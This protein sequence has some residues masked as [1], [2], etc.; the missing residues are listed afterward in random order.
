PRS[1]SPRS[2]DERRRSHLRVLSRARRA[3][4]AAAAAVHAGALRRAVVHR[5]PPGERA[6]VQGHPARPGGPRR[7]PPAVRRG[8][9]AVARPAR[10][11]AHAHR[12]GAALVARVAAAAALRAVPRL[13]WQLERRAERAVP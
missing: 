9:G 8:P 13:P 2:D 6:L 7:G 4:V 12:L 10:E 1:T 11:R 3:A 5:R